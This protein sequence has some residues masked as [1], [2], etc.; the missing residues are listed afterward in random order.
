MKNIT[1]VT[2]ESTSSRAYVTR[3][4]LTQTRRF[5]HSKFGGKKTATQSAYKYA[6]WLKHEASDAQFDT[7]NRAPG[8]PM[9]SEFF[10]R[11]IIKN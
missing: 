1:N 8:R 3:E 9:K 2:I 6:M 4:G 5:L 10:G 11:R 7:A